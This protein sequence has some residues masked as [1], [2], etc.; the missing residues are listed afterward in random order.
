MLRPLLRAALTALFFCSGAAAALA[1]APAPD[2]NPSA[3]PV[4][5]LAAP[6]A[7]PTAATSAAP[8]PTPT[9]PYNRIG[10]REVGPAVSG[11]R[12]TSVTGVADDPKLYYLGTAGGGVW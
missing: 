9:P 2:A 4:P 6:S 5:A 11:G 12:I 1:Q 3:P 7:A 10:F 8:S